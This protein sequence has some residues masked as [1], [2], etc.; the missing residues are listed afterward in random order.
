M[1]NVLLSGMMKMTT[2]G[3]QTVTE[4]EYLRSKGFK[5][6]AR[7]RFSAEMKAA[8]KEAGYNV[9]EARKV[10]PSS[11][12]PK[13]QT[14]RVAKPRNPRPTPD[15]ASN[16]RQ[17]RWYHVRDGKKIFI[18]GANGC[19]NCPYSLDYHTCGTPTALVKGELGYVRVYTA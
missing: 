18:S 3:W 9:G 14:T 19:G 1:T 11:P 7:G 5:V 16:A 12:Q 6:G 15:A 10:S 13:R 2:E 17:V 8:L 4:R